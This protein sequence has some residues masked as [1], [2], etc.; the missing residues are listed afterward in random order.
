LLLSTE[1]GKMMKRKIYF[2]ILGIF[3]VLA[4]IAGLFFLRYFSPCHTDE[5]EVCEGNN[6]SC[7]SE[8]NF[9]VYNDGKVEE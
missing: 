3:F 1:E 7:V 6:C 9:I 4:I 2:G 5:L 8:K